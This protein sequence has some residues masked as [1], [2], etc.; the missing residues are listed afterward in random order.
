MITTSDND[1]RLLKA[2]IYRLLARSFGYPSDD[3]V[4][5]IT[6][7]SSELTL[8]RFPDDAIHYLIS[9]LAHE[10]SAEEMQRYYSTIFI[11]GGVPLT[12]S[13]NTNAYNSVADVSAYYSA[14]GVTPRSGDTPDSIMY[15]LEF[16]ALLHVKLVAA[17][18]EASREVTQQA[19]KSFLA[20][21]VGAFALTFANKVLNGDSGP[22]YRTAAE[23]LN[24]FVEK[25]MLA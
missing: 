9:T 7:I 12:Q 5:A 14:F 18:D 20:D 1:V 24:S 8:A 11:S 19:L 3:N 25:E 2:D 4:R 21:H 23:L 13:H 22:F 17:P 15:Q 16:T 10:V 6:D